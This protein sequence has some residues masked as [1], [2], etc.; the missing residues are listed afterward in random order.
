MV[1]K[2]ARLEHIIIINKAP[3]AAGEEPL[4]FHYL[5]LLTKSEATRLDR[6]LKALERDEIIINYNVQT[7]DIIYND[8]DSVDKEINKEIVS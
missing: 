2:L 8:I 7:V 4:P 5:A 1:G 3:E 6:R